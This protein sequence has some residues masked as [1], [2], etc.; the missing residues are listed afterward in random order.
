MTVKNA[1]IG[2]VT[3]AAVWNGTGDVTP[4]A[5]VPVNLTDAS[6]G[7]AMMFNGSV[8]VEDTRNTVVKYETV[9]LTFNDTAS[10]G[11]QV[12]GW[13]PVSVNALAAEIS[14]T[15]Y[16]C[17]RLTATDPSSA[18]YVGAYT[19]TSHVGAAVPVGYIHVAA[20]GAITYH[21][22]KS[23]DNQ[24]DLSYFTFYYSISPMSTAAANDGIDNAANSY[25]TIQATIGARESDPA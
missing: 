1:D 17:L 2:D 16:D 8:L 12:P 9:Q 15:Q 13:Y 18:G 14:S 11:D 20:N 22:Q 19:Y 21:S 5:L 7:K 4:K 23:N 24:Y 3:F 10:K 25:G 6:N